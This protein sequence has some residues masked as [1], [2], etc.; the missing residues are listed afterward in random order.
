MLINCEKTCQTLSPQKVDKP[1]KVSAASALEEH[2]ERREDDGE[3]AEEGL[4]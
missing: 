4:I 1:H 3:A 2:A